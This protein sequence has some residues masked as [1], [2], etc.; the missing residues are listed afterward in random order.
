MKI[1]LATVAIFFSALSAAQLGVY[2]VCN[3][4]LNACYTYLSENI[5]T[6][7]EDVNVTSKEISLPFAQISLKNTNAKKLMTVVFL[8]QGN[9]MA[10]CHKV[11]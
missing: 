8:I 11:A 4:N 9:K 10:K 7:C 6:L 1:A 5:H 2:G 3:K